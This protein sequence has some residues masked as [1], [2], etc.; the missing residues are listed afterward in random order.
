MTRAE[1]QAS[2]K[3]ADGE[4]YIQVSRLVREAAPIGL[5]AIGAPKDEHDVEVSTILP[6]LREATSARDVQRII[7]EEFVHWFGGEIAGASAAY[8]TV[9]EKVWKTW[10]ESAAGPSTG[11]AGNGHDGAAR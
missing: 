7:H 4:L 9:A 8:A 3:E 11:P 2:L 6:R 5:I 10:Q 1:R